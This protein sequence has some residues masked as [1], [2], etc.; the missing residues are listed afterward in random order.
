VW[1]SFC[2]LERAAAAAP[3]SQPHF[4]R[5]APPAICLVRSSA[6]AV[7]TTRHSRHNADTTHHA[8]HGFMAAHTGTG[9]LPRYWM[10]LPNAGTRLPAAALYAAFKVSLCYL[11][12]ASAATVRRALF[13]STFARCLQPSDTVAA[14]TCQLFPIC[15]FAGWNCAVPHG[16]RLQP[17]AFALSMAFYHR[18]YTCHHLYM[19][20]HMP[21]LDML[22]YTPFLPAAPS[23]TVKPLLGPDDSFISFHSLV[24]SSLPRSSPCLPPPCLHL[25]K[26][27]LPGSACM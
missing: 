5:Y 24:L 8:L 14:G 2:A 20:F 23:I 6:G 19:E 16:C 27:R 1:V 18:V 3:P 9:L 15:G 7:P 4:T 12:P 26:F 21:L 13:H 22:S 10:G 25:S 17:A 11:A